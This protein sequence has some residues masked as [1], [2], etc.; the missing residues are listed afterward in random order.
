MD[1]DFIVVGSGF[2]GSVSAHR[3][4]EKGYRVGVME[5]GRRWTPE[6]LPRTNWKLWRWIWRPGLGL[7]GFF[8]IEPFRHVMI[9]HGCAVGGGSITY[10]N[11]LLVPRRRDLGERI[12]GGPGGL[13]GG[14][15]AAL[16]DGAAHAGRRGEPHPRSGGPHPEARGRSARRGRDLLPHA[17]CGLRRRRKAKPAGRPYPD[18]YF[19]GEGPERTTCIGCGGCMMGCRYNAKN[20]LDKNYLYLAEKRGARVFAETRVVDVRPLDGS[21]DGSDGYEVRTVPSTAWR[22]PGARAASP[23]A[24]W[25]SP[26]RR[27]ARWICSSA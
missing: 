14:D 18:P 12:V 26:P 21:A 19:G 17:G 16:R 3:L 24:A 2:G 15:A 25:S 10:A 4:T 6:N 11:T 1:F 23:A 7:R 20:T 9:M 27:S 5:M 22:A 13:E 8:N